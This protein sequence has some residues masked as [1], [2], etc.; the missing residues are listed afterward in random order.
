MKPPSESKKRNIG[1]QN[2]TRQKTEL[3]LEHHFA[4]TMDLEV[5][6]ST[7]LEYCE[8]VRNFHRIERCFLSQT[9]SSFAAV[10]MRRRIAE[11]LLEQAIFHGCPLSI[12][13]YRVNAAKSPGFT[14]IE[15]EAHCYLLYAQGALARGH[16]K[17]ARRTASEIAGKLE[18]SLRKKKSLPALQLLQSTHKLLHSIDTFKTTFRNRL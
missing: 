9:K 7:T 10:E 3:D 18:A 16:F 11:Q 2:R 8:V 14:N 5:I 15:R 6:R 17:T 4:R 13:R 1:Q 12:C